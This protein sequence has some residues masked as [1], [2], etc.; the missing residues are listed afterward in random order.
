M[1]KL[2]RLGHAQ[3][4]IGKVQRRIWLA[5]ALAWPTALAAGAATVGTV[6]WFMR[7]RSAGGRHEMPDL[8]GA[9][10]DGTVHVETDGQLT[11]N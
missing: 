11:H 10:E 2:S 5:Q 7:R 8:P 4:R 6:V 3:Q 1:D 9:H